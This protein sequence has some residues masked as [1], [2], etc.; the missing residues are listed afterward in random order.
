MSCEQWKMIERYPDYFISSQG[1]VFS[2]KKLDFL[3]PRL[4]GKG[5]HTVYINKKINGH[6]RNLYIHRLVGKAFIA[7]PAGKPMVDHINHI[8]TDNRLEN[9]RWA[10]AKENGLN[11][12]LSSRNKT[13]VRGVALDK[14]SGKYYARITVDGIATFIGSYPTLQ[15][16]KEARKRVVNSVFKNSE[17]IHPNERM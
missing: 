14:K 9:L 5:Y 4:V 16:A 1:R 17:F 2:L 12:D 7:N 13:G 3:K 6:K 10:T 8:I 15:E 11:S